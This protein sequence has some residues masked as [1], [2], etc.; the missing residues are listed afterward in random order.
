[1]FFSH[2]LCRYY[3][4][5]T[6]EIIEAPQARSAVV[7]TRRPSAVLAAPWNIV[8]AAFVALAL[9]S[10]TEVVKAQREVATITQ[11]T[12]PGPVVVNPVTNRIY[13]AKFADSTVDVVDGATNLV[14]QTII[15]PSP[16]AMAVNTDTNRIYVTSS[17]TNAVSV[18]DGATSTI[19]ST[20]SVGANPVTVAVNPVT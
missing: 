19:S 14:L 9:L 2:S 15:S 11:D 4:S 17:N 8:R 6:S 3:C 12:T 7:P 5:K 16:V 18:I 20:V 10:S 1:M 13:I